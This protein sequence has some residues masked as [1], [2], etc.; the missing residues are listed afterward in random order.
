MPKTSRLKLTNHSLVQGVLALVAQKKPTLLASW[1]FSALLAS[2]IFAVNASTE[3]ENHYSLGSYQTDINRVL[4]KDTSSSYYLIPQMALIQYSTIFIKKTSKPVDKLPY[5]KLPKQIE[6]YNKSINLLVSTGEFVTPHVTINT[7]NLNAS[8]GYSQNSTEP[9]LS[10]G[11]ALG[12][13]LRMGLKSWWQ[14]NEGSQLH[15]MSKAAP[16]S[17]RSGKLVG[18]SKFNWDYSLKVSYDDVKLR[19]EKDF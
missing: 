9:Y 8:H 10:G 11:S 3:P 7:L 14:N 1:I 13:V 15:S 12:A 4:S 2:H 6:A 18:K 17:V 16:E 5:R 19:F